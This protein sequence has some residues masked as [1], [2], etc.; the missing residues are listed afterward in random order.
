MIISSVLTRLGGRKEPNTM[1]ITKFSGDPNR[2]WDLIK[3]KQT[4]RVVQPVN[5]AS[6]KPANHTRFVFISDTHNRTSRMDPLPEGDVLIHAGDFTFS[7][8][9][10]EVVKFNDYLGSL[11]H[12]HKIVIAGNHDVTLDE[13]NYPY[14]WR[15]FG[16]TQHDSEAVRKSLTNCVYLQDEEIMVE[17]FRIY[18][19]PW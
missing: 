5:L 7:G 13:E 2:A 6:P 15:F 9:P 1:D 17:G 14:L 19:S 3:N 11:T 4:V 8:R 10:E 18:G 12:T 16:R